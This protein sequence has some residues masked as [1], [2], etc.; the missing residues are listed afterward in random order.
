MDKPQVAQRWRDL[1]EQLEIHR[2]ER[3]ERLLAPWDAHALDTLRERADWLASAFE[4]VH[5]AVDSGPMPRFSVALDG[6]LEARETSHRKTR[7]L[8]RTLAHLKRT[9]PRIKEEH[10]VLLNL[11]ASVAQFRRVR[12]QIRREQIRMK[13]E[14]L[15]V[16]AAVWLDDPKAATDLLDRL[17]PYLEPLKPLPRGGWTRDRV[18]RPRRDDSRDVKEALKKA[19]IPSRW[20]RR[21][22]IAGATLHPK[23]L[24]DAILMA[25]GLVPL[26]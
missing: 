8:A 25:V 26:R 15:H 24:H 18:G 9:E 13:Q 22:Q 20:P 6:L 4:T 1:A 19:G 7:A 2:P 14:P 23:S 21:P 12:E 11:R 5:A 16:G 17:W 3:F 10:R